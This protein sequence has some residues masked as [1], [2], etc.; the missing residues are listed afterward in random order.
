M[1]F[2]APANSDVLVDSGVAV[3]HSISGIHIRGMCVLKY[4]LVLFLCLFGAASVANAQAV[5]TASRIGDLQVGGFYSNANMDYGPF[6]ATG[7]GAFFD[8]DF[9]H[10]F[11]AEG[12]FRF[13]K[14]GSSNLYEKTYEIG[15]RYYHPFG[16]LVPYGK[17]LYGRGV[18]N[19]TNDGVTVANL[20]YNMFAIGGG[21]DYR[22]L[23]SVN[24]RADYEY[25]KWLSFPPDGLSPT[26]FTIG[27][28]YHFH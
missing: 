2:N 9:T 8:F 20:A 22:L 26:V 3:C 27:G 6:R 16:K 4:L 25:Q 7:G 24:L 13:V 1:T 28:A 5:P 18:F 17:L 11:G 21:V 19:F 15:G 12:E 10:R 14:E 23:R